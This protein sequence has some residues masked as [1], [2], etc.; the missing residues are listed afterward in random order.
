M[1]STRYILNSVASDPN[2]EPEL[3]ASA[4]DKLNRMEARNKRHQAIKDARAR[5]FREKLMEVLRAADGLPLTTTEIQLLLYS[6]YRVRL[7]NQKVSRHLNRMCYDINWDASFVW[8]IERDSNRRDVCFWML[9]S[10]CP[11]VDE[12]NPKWGYD[13]TFIDWDG[14]C[15][16]EAFESFMK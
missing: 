11:T 7:S 4:I 14:I 1:Y 5:Q 13:R 3:R 15:G 12:I 10:K 8:G 9:E 16:L 6:K 2:C